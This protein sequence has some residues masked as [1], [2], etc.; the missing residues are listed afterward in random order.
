MTL[1]MY[2]QQK[3]WPV[4]HLRVSVMHQKD[5]DQSP[6]DLFTRAITISGDVDAAQRARMIE[7]AEK[8][9]VHKTLTSGARIATAEA[10][11]S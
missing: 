2:A 7:I 3:G 5:K 6:P 1:R 8:C 11:Q 4:D 9:P 10:R